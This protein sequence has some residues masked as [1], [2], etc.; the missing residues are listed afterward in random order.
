MRDKNVIDTLFTD[1]GG[2]LLTNGWDRRSRRR[3]VEIFDLDFEEMDERHHL[4]FDTYEEGKLNLDEY[5]RRV[6]FYKKRS[7]SPED[8]KK[9]MFSRSQPYDDMFDLIRSLKKNYGLRVI[10]VSNEGRELTE[11]RIREFDLDSFIDAFVSSCFVH[12]RKPDKDIYRIALDISQASPESVVY[13]DDREMFVQIAGE[14]GIR[15]IHHT[16]C[17]STRESFAGIGLTVLDGEIPRERA[18]RQ[19]GRFNR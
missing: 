12:F 19:S 7:F 1:I 3:A 2:V 13:I 5:L 10:A 14:L 17:A 15:G 4:T 9:F 16:D 6:V 11:Y 8:F 18:G